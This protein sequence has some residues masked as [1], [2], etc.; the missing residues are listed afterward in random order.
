MENIESVKDPSKEPASYC[1][2]IGHGARIPE[3]SYGEIQI[4]TEKAKIRILVNGTV[5]INGTV[6]GV[7]EEV[8]HRFRSWL[9]YWVGCPALPDRPLYAEV[10]ELFMDDDRSHRPFNEDFQELKGVVAMGPGACPKEDYEIVLR[11]KHGDEVRVRAGETP[12]PTE[13]MSS[14]RALFCMRV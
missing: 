2:A 9:G 13:M 6:V 14:L 12:D 1:V 7:D 3:H 4:A 5:E 8:G 10:G 11:N